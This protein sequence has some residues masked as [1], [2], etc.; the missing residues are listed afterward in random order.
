MVTDLSHH[1]PLLGDGSDAFEARLLAAD[2][3]EVADLY[4]SLA[5]M[6]GSD[7]WTAQTS[8]D[9]WSMAQTI[10]HLDIMTAAGLRTAEMIAQ[11]RQQ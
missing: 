4:A 5:S 9:E 3:E 2:L 1:Q 7:S 10:A 6:V 8:E 11:R